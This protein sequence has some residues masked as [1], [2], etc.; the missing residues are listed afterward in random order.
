MTET[1]TTDVADSSATD[2]A[3]TVVE[4]AVYEVL[5]ADAF[6]PRQAELHTD[7]RR[8]GGMVA[9]LARR[10]VQEPGLFADVVLWRDLAAAEAASEAVERDPQL[11]WFRDLLGEIR[12]F[13][14]FTPV[15][16]VAL[17]R[18]A[19]APLLEVAI[20]RP[21]RPAAHAAAHRALHRELATVPEVHSSVPLTR[22]DGAVTADLIGWPDVATWT[23]TGEAMMSEPG[24]RDFFDPGTE[25]LVLALFAETDR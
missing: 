19:A 16:P 10:G 13:G 23:N 20:S 6:A 7:L 4:L 2:T 14:H 1:P 18:L 9:S 12:F 24:L 25:Q 22:D 5:D 11:S 15:G 3:T 21:A 17:D 8:R